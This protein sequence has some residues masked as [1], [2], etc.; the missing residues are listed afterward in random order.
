MSLN[1]VLCRQLTSIRRLSFL[2]VKRGRENPYWFLDVTRRGCMQRASGNAE[3]RSEPGRPFFL[4]CAQNRFNESCA[5]V[6]K[7]R[8]RG[9]R[10]SASSKSGRPAGPRAKHGP[11]ASC[12]SCQD[13]LWNTSVLQRHPAGG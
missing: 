2:P 13:L 8:G 11:P 3:A 9:S 1:P 6:L 7:D 4:L 5:E 12:E 10:A